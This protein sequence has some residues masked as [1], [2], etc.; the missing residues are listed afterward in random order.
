MNLITRRTLSTPSDNPYGFDFF[1]LHQFI[2][3]F[4][5]GYLEKYN[6]I[7]RRF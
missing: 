7:K 1:I 4:K 3:V 5:N 2:C 6:F